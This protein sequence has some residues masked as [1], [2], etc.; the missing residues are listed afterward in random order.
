MG[1]DFNI[2]TPA[3]STTTSRVPTKD[4]G[5]HIFVLPVN[6]KEF[7][8]TKFDLLLGDLEKIAEDERCKLL[9]TNAMSCQQECFM[10]D[11][12][13]RGCLGVIV[14]LIH[15]PLICKM[16]QEEFKQKIEDEVFC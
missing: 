2:T 9:H 7:Y 15:D 6:E 3:P 11:D 10:S 14:G 5:I 1:N 8:E 16:T 12:P 13:D 4:D